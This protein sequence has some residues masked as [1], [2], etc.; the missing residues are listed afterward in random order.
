MAS[1]SGAGRIAAQSQHNADCIA[2]RRTL[3]NHSRRGCWLL[4]WPSAPCAASGRNRPALGISAARPNAF[5]DAVL[6]PVLGPVQHILRLS[7]VIR[8]LSRSSQP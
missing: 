1:S 5:N 2:L 6:P 8:C 3:S 4:G 7:Q